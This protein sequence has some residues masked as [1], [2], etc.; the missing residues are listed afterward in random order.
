M[1][2]LV[3]IDAVVL[4]IWKFELAIDKVMLKAHIL[5]RPDWTVIWIFEM[6]LSSFKIRRCFYQDSNE[7]KLLLRLIMSSWE[8]YVGRVDKDETG[9]IDVVVGDYG[10]RK[11]DTSA[12]IDAVKKQRILL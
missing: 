4:K 11:P 10:D 6:E 2:N 1:Q 9:Q 7:L 3:A 5:D 8:F 12:D